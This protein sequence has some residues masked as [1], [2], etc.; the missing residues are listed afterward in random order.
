LRLDATCR[1]AGA[2]LRRSPVPAP[3]TARAPPFAEKRFPARLGLQY[4][5]VIPILLENT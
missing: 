4:L 5:V 1:C 2:P 3:F